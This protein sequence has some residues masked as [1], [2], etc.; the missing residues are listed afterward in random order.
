MSYQDLTNEEM[1]KLI[2]ERYQDAKNSGLF[3]D[4]AMVARECGKY[5][6][7]RYGPKYKFI[8]GDIAVYVDDFGGY[9]TTHVGDK[10]M[11]ST[12][13][14][15]PFFISGVWVDTVLS[16]L[17]EARLRIDQRKAIEEV[18]RRSKLINMLGN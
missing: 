6:N 4:I 9:M 12:H 17:D 16:R 13:P 1:Q 5:L 10:K 15:Q 2:K 18:E 14:C 11:L 7:V 8:D 3:G